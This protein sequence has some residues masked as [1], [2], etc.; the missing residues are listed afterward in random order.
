[1]RSKTSWFNRTLFVKNLARFWPVWALYA[2]VW[3]FILPVELATRTHA[4]DSYQ[5][6]NLFRF[7]HAGVL[8]MTSITVVTAALFG[9]LA[10]MCVFSYLYNSRSVGMY[11]SLPVRREGLFLTSYL[12]GLSFLWGPAVLVFL[13]TLVEEAAVGCMNVGALCMW[14]TVHLLC[15][16]FFYSFAVFC[17]MF[18]G[19]LL[20]LPAF[21][22][23]LNFLATGV[24]TVLDSLLRAFLYGYSGVELVQKAGIWLTPV[25]QLFDGF[26]VRFDPNMS[27]DTGE[28][29]ASGT[30]KAVFSG[31]HYA[32]IYG[33][34]GVLLALAALWLYRRRRLESAGDVVAVGWVRPVF[35]YGVGAC[36]ALTLGP[37]LYLGILGGRSLGGLLA[38]MLPCGAVGYFVAEMLLQKSF[39][40]FARWKGCVVLVAAVAACVGFVWLDPLGFTEWTPDPAKVE[41][42]KT[43]MFSY[44]NDDA[45][46][47]LDL[48]DPE[49]IALLVRAHA[50]MT[51]QEEAWKA[52]LWDSV[53]SGQERA[54]LP[55]GGTYSYSTVEGNGGMHLWYLMKDGHS[56]WRDYS[57]LFTQEQLEDPNSYASILQGMLNSPEHRAE[58]YPFP[59]SETARLVAGDLNVF[60]AET[61]EVERVTVPAGGLEE[62][63]AAV[64]SDIAAGRLGVR[65]LIENRE[66]MENCYYNDLTLGFYDPRNGDPYA[67]AEEKYGPRA[68]LSVEDLTNRQVT[69]TLQASATETLAVLEKLGVVD[70]GHTLTTWAEY[71]A[72]RE[73]QVDA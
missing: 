58:M 51:E 38:W 37:L 66:R 72:W 16:L 20:A 39:R 44:P 41:S 45:S 62:L 49:D 36:T 28:L 12:S 3:I 33:F 54:T 7:V 25:A 29:L 6:Q 46:G 17:A 26:Q 18:T 59:D 5:F 14:L 40:V 69:I 35:R 47:A 30:V 64:R 2:V 67:A 10:A 57:L 23:I 61:W 34:I 31:L 52:G 68:T 70:E 19:N 53:E 65:Y 42:V 1:M 27:G 60:N 32:L 50:S 4:E 55:D 9:V 21:Y 15:I 56:V 8:E 43:N 22:G 63:Y 71:R 11:H 13:I 73:S 24:W 48:D